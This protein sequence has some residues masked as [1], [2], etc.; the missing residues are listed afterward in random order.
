MPTAAEVESG[1]EVTKNISKTFAEF[2]RFG[3]VGGSGVIVNLVVT[4]IMTQLNGGTANYNRVV[5]S[6]GGLSFRFTLVV[7][8]VAFVIANIWNFQINRSWTFKR[9]EKRSWWAEFWPFFTV[10]L[11]AA[12]VGIL[13]KEGFTN[14]DSVMYLPDPPF[15]DHE[16]IRAREYWSQLFTIVITTP[17]NYLVNKVWTFRAIKQ[18]KD[19]TNVS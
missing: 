17:I 5:F 7:W 12:C 16:G 2:I 19:Q 9:S 11:V 10:G 8:V 6:L 14:P 13:L 18:N 15:N 4:Y 1:C 3:L